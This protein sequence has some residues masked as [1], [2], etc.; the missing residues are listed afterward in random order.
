M[1][2]W[3]ILTDMRL[4]STFILLCLLS[5][6][7]APTATLPPPSPLTS[8][9]LDSDK[10]NDSNWLIVDD[11][12]VISDR[13]DCLPKDCAFS[14]WEV[15]QPEALGLTVS[16][17]SLELVISLRSFQT[18]EDADSHVEITSRQYAGQPGKQWVE[19]PANILPDHSVAYAE[20]GRYVVLITV[21]RNILITFS[22][23]SS[24]EGIYETE[25]AVDLLANLAKIQIDKL[26]LQ[27]V[28]KYSKNMAGCWKDI[29]LLT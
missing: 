23:S 22:L 19:I 6:C 13:E 20:D 10:I 15:L 9:I 27:T 24:T 12:L 29:R 18:P 2:R 4:I 17:S 11:G 28:S 7:A 16:N 3:I 25:K 14:V 8:F 5:A 1:I 21:D 26:R